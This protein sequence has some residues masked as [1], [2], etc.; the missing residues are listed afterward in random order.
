MKKL[1]LLCALATSLIGGGYVIAQE[2]EQLTEVTE[3]SIRILG[4]ET[5]KASDFIAL[6]NKTTAN[7]SFG[8]TGIPTNGTFIVDESFSTGYLN[9]NAGGETM[10]VE[11]KEGKT[12][13]VST[14]I[15]G[16]GGNVANIYG[17]GTYIVDMTNNESG[18]S[19]PLFL[20]A[21]TIFKNSAFLN[22]GSKVTVGGGKTL[23]TEKSYLRLKGNAKLTI[24]EVDEQGNVVS[25][26]NLAV[27]TSQAYK[28]NNMSWLV[29]QGN[30]NV[31][32]I[33]KDSTAS[34]GVFHGI[35]EEYTSTEDGGIDLTVNGTMNVGFNS[36]SWRKSFAF[37]GNNV[38]VGKS[39]IINITDTNAYA[40]MFI[41]RSLDNAGTISIATGNNLYMS[42]NSTLTLRE[43]SDIR[44]NGVASQKDSVIYLQHGDYHYTD[45][46]EKNGV[47]TTGTLANVRVILEADQKLGGFALRDGATLT[48]DLNENALAL[49]GITVQNGEI[50]YLILDDFINKSLSVDEDKTFSLQDVQASYKT[51][52]I[53]NYMYIDDLEW[54]TENGRSYLY[55]ASLAAIPEPAEWAMIFGAIALGFVAYRRRS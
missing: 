33:N 22:T 44:T 46:V 23:S 18:T 8:K 1:T 39:G 35:K 27:Y 32:T 36:C 37:W 3:T 11:I 17:D 42:D 13:T 45:G 19:T 12:F 21:N 29:A 51:D 4:N 25:T 20:H 43:G 14:R 2:S 34:M 6:Y 49:G 24:G 5:Y 31:L 38:T 40:D 50:F 15:V 41:K 52:D 28:D 10:N 53:D 26:G 30:G 7:L 47:T 9:P 54:I 55:S 48:I 16:A